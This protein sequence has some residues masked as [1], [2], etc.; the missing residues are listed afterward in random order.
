[1]I[2]HASDIPFDGGSRGWGIHVQNLESGLVS[3]NIIASLEGSQPVAI[4]VG[5]SVPNQV[6]P[7]SV[8]IL[9]NIVYNHRNDSLVFQENGGLMSAF[10]DGNV[11]YEAAT[12]EPPF[13]W[14]RILVRSRETEE[15]FNQNYSF[16]VNHYYSALAESYWFGGFAG[17]DD[18][19]SWLSYSGD[20]GGVQEED[21][22]QRNTSVSIEAF[23]ESGAESP[24][25][26]DEWKAA[27]A[28]Q[29]LGAWDPSLEAQV[30]I[31][32]FR[33]GFGKDALTE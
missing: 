33:V 5:I 7:G 30:A 27:L 13:G 19:A 3:E 29:R 10:V 6:D 15:E 12:V 20:G 11:F 9:S 17:V 31:N 28:E 23:L 16:G 24:M 32:W 26:Y 2:L 4:D 18:F 22:W 8:Q 21:P 14:A 1:V 25:A